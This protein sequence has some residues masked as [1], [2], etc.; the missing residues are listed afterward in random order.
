MIFFS[1]FTL[2]C[3]WNWWRSRRDIYSKRRPNNDFFRLG[4]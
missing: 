4:L 1:Y 3:W 2:L